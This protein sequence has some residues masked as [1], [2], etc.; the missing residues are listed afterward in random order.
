M[1]NYFLLSYQWLKSALDRVACEYCQ[2]SR[3]EVFYKKD[4]FKNFAKLTGKQL[5]KSL[6]LNK[7]AGFKSSTLLKKS[8]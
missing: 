1:R 6:F 7:V 8:L 4:V 3:P 5:W 2:R